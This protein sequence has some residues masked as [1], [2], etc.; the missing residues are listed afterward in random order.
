MDQVLYRIKAEASKDEILERLKKIA[1]VK[2]PFIIPKGVKFLGTVNDK[3]FKLKTFHAPPMEFEFKT[4]DDGIYFRYKRNS[5]VADMKAMIYAV[6]LPLF[7]T[8]ILF[9]ALSN[10]FNWFG[11]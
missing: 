5:M 6:L 4:L 8:V 1:L 10:D 9:S 7:F 11:T 3:E 2:R